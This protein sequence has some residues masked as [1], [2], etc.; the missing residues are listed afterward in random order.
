[1]KKL[2]LTAALGVACVSALAQGSFLFNNGGN[3][4]NAPV[5]D[6]D[7]TTK[8]GPA[9][10]ADFY[11]AAG[12]VTDSTLL[13]DLNHPISFAG[14]GFFLGGV[15]SIPGTGAQTITAQVRVWDA[16]S[17][18]SWAQA[19]VL[20][21][22]KVGESALFSLALV[23]G[24]TPPNALANMTS[25]SVS[26]VAVPEPSTLALAGLGLAGLLV[27]RRRK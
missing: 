3:G 4:A 22:A 2:I 25:F 13:A 5:F 21:G 20:P 9:F 19:A 11:W 16:A 27:L 23:T 1:M 6:T 17:G 8:L 12:T 14:S 15:T 26:I 7:G 10:K 24:A 18:S